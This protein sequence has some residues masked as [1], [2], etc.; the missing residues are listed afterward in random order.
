MKGRR[1]EALGERGK[2]EGLGGEGNEG[3]IRYKT[4]EWKGDQRKAECR[5]SKEI[6]N[7]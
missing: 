7:K 5:Q 4:W 6:K 1:T 2:G 3:R